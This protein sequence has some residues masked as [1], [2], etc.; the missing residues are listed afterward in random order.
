MHCAFRNFR[1]LTSAMKLTLPLGAVAF[2][3]CAPSI[4]S[5]ACTPTGYVRDSID[6]TAALINPWKVSGD[7]DATGCNIGVYYSEGKRGLVK[8]ANIHGANYFGIVNNGA[9]VDILDSTISDIGEKPFNGSQ[10]GIAIY[11]VYQSAAR[12]DIQGN[13]IWNYQKGG[14]AVNGASARANIERNTVIGLGPV[15]F[16]AQNGIQAGYNA[17]VKIER[18]FVSGNSYTG[19]ST[20]SAGILLVGGSCY[21]GGDP[22]TNTKVQGNTVVNN[23]VGVALSNLG[24][25]YPNCP[26]PVTTPTKNAVVSN[27][28]VNNAINNGIYQAGISVAGSSDVIWNNDVCG[29]GYPETPTTSA[30]YL[31]GI[32]LDWALDVK[33][34][35]NTFCSAG[36]WSWHGNSHVATKGRAARAAKQGRSASPVR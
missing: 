28:A 4:A 24:G 12:G 6:L 33:A 34:N 20:Y 26:G 1:S 9:K 35:H 14:I 8:N 2:A 36:S 18:N 32:D 25:V 23:D 3:L 15:G 16:I 21:F 11:F 27:T 5:A 19:S 29:P 31:Y 22:Q 7:V 30:P 10:H 17:D 13:T